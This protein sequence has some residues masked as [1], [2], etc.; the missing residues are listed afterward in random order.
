MKKF[1]RQLG[2]IS[3]VKRKNTYFWNVQR[4]IPLAPSIVKS[5]MRTKGSWPQTNSLDNEEVNWRRVGEMSNWN[6]VL[7]EGG[8]PECLWDAWAVVLAVIM[9]WYSQIALVD[10]TWRSS[11]SR[12]RAPHICELEL[13]LWIFWILMSVYGINSSSPEDR[14][15]DYER[16]LRRGG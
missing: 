13:V 1:V 16:F 10:N 5:A 15:A 3:G 7:G 6:L 9:R 11:V 2:R 4:T 8:V 14:R 12:T